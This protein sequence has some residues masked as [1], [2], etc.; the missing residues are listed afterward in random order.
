MPPKE[1]GFSSKSQLHI[2][3]RVWN[4]TSGN[5]LKKFVG[6]DRVNKGVIKWIW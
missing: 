4:K 2:W 6:G 1:L 5:N 3:L